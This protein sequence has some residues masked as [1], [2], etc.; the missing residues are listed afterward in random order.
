VYIVGTTYTY[1]QLGHG[2]VFLLKWDLTGDLRTG[3]I[4]Y[5]KVWGGYNQTDYGYGVALDP[6]GNV[7]VTGTTYSYG[8]NPGLPSAFLLKYNSNGQLLSQKIWGGTSADYG[9]GV[10]T[11][12]LG[13]VYMTGTTYSY[14]MTPEHPNVFLVKYDPSGNIIYQKTWGGAEADY[15]Y[16]V[17]VDQLGNAYVTG[18][19]YSFGPNP[20]RTFEQ[21]TTYQNLAALFLLKY[22]SNGNLWWQRIWSGTPLNQ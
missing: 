16:S 14:S 18:Y 12:N 5:L 3:E 2:A 1:G 6:E 7:Y 13:N 11:D 17:A 22:D 8:L 21:S 20:Q 4:S 19:T 9:Y 15:G 10:A